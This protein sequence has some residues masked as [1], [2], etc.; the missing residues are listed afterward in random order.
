MNGSPVVRREDI[1]AVAAPALRHRIK[2]NFQAEADGVTVDDII[3]Q[4]I[5]SVDASLAS[6]ASSEQIAKVLRP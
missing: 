3:A 5:D 1:E 6:S 2:L 4:V